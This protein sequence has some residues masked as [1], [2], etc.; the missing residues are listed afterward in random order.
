MTRLYLFAGFLRTD[1]KEPTPE[2]LLSGAAIYARI[3][4]VDGVQRYP[5]WKKDRVLDILRRQLQSHPKPPT[6]TEMRAAD[7]RVAFESSQT[8]DVRLATLEHRV[9]ELERFLRRGQR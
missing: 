5:R 4:T 2:A 6:K 8:V 9:E 7:Q 3:N 1:T